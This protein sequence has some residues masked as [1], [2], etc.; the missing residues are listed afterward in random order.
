MNTVKIELVNGDMN[1]FPTKGSIDS[2]CYDLKAREI[3]KVNDGYYKVK[4]GIKTEIPEGYF[5]PLYARSSITDSPW[6]LCNGVGIIDS[7]FRNEW[8]A[9]FR[10]FPN[11]TAWELVEIENACEGCEENEVEINQVPSLVLTYP[12]FP[13]NVGDRVAQTK[14]VKLE[15]YEFAIANISDTERGL[16]GFGST[17]K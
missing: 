17:G 4:L 12:E 6:I 2:A 14:L 9:R 15:D 1:Y 5:M 10:A 11:G 13:Y 16:G 3:I 7:D 8:Q